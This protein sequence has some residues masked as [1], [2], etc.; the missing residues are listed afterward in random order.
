MRLQKLSGSFKQD[1]LFE[2]MFILSHERSKMWV[3]CCVGVVSPNSQPIKAIMGK[4][5]LL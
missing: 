5:L 2:S 3:V 1:H 4:L